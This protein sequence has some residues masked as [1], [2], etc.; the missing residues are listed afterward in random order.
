[1]TVAHAMI[2]VHEFEWLI[3]DQEPEME[4]DPRNP[5]YQDLADEFAGEASTAEALSPPR[6]MVELPPAPQPE[7]EPAPN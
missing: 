5:F 1:M 3:P 6:P 7:P 4:D 2:P